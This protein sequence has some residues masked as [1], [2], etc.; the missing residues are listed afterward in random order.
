MCVTSLGENREPFWRDITRIDRLIYGHEKKLKSC[1]NKKRQCYKLLSLLTDYD[2]WLS[3]TCERYAWKIRA[4]QMVQTGSMGRAT[5][6]D[7][8]CN[9]RISDCASSRTPCTESKKYGHLAKWTS[10]HVTVGERFRKKKK[11][12]KLRCGKIAEKKIGVKIKDPKKFQLHGTGRRDEPSRCGNQ[13]VQEDAEGEGQEGEENGDEAVEDYRIDAS[14]NNEEE[15]YENKGEL[16]CEENETCEETG[17]RG[18]DSTEGIHPNEEPTVV[19]REG[20]LEVEE[21]EKIYSTEEKEKKEET[22]H[23]QI[24]HK[25]EGEKNEENLEGV[26]S[27]IMGYPHEMGKDD[28]EQ[29]AI[30]H[31]EDNGLECSEVQVMGVTV[32]E[33]EEDIQRGGIPDDGD[34]MAEGKGKVQK[35]KKT[36][37]KKGD[38]KKKRER[39]GEKEKGKT[40]KKKQK[41]TMMDEGEEREK[42]SEEEIAKA[43]EKTMDEGKGVKMKDVEE[44][45]ME[46][47]KESKMVEENEENIGDEKETNPGEEQGVMVAEEQDTT[48]NEGKEESMEGEKEH[49]EQVKVEKETEV[50]I[51]DEGNAKLDV[52]KEA[53]VQGEQMYTGGKKQKEL[54]EDSTIGEFTEEK[55]GHEG[56]AKV[57]ANKDQNSGAEEDTHVAPANDKEQEILNQ[58][59]PIRSD[60]ENDPGKTAENEIVHNILSEYSNTIQYTSFLDYIKNKKEPE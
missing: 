51:E 44:E 32:E 46:K 47:A 56:E 20:V 14:E 1:N 45:K 36:K 30:E 33:E 7:E 3:E 4:L 38:T 29:E 15:V 12:K 8:K 59:E 18:A 57:D 37:R 58:D 55:I 49:G 31:N 35:E 52:E 28:D 21:E 22:R 26:P 10:V 13:K 60:L 25:S 27:D 17:A 48:V 39:K 43:M 41:Q 5:R 16:P 6:A 9:S 53:T 50:M 19:E 42:A 54:S 23:F 2:N 34:E 40:K 24:V 11:K